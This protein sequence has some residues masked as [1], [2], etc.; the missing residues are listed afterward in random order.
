MQNQSHLASQRCS[1]ENSEAY[2]NC[3]SPRINTAPAPAA[4]KAVARERAIEVEIRALTRSPSQ[5]PTKSIATASTHSHSGVPV[6]S[7]P[8][9][10]TSFNRKETVFA[11]TRTGCSVATNRSEEHTSEL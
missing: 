5:A 7:T 8:P 11:T 3:I 9:S 6:K 1:W 4:A 10:K 2:T